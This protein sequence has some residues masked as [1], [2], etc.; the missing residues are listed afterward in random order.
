MPVQIYI[1]ASSPELGFVDKTAAGI[2]LLIL[3]LLALNA[4]AI[5]VRKRYE[6]RW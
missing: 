3:L 1:W 4:V 5:Y 2:L 6:R